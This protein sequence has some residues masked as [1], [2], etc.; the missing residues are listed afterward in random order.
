MNI[1]GKKI[2]SQQNFAARFAEIPAKIPEEDIPPLFLSESQKKMLASVCPVKYKSVSDMADTDY[3]E[4]FDFEY[5]PLSKQE[6]LPPFSNTGGRNIFVVKTITSLIPS[7]QI[8]SCIIDFLS[9]SFSVNDFYS[10]EIVDIEVKVKRFLHE[11]AVF[12]P[13]LEFCFLD[14]GLFG[15]QK[16]ASLKRLEQ[17][18][19]L[20]GFGGNSGTIFFSLSGQG[21]VGVDMYALK[22]YVETLPDCHIT[23][24]DMAHDDLEGLNTVV[25]FRDRFLAGDF[26]HV[27]RIAPKGRFYD[28]LGCDTGKTLYV[29]AKKHGKECC[30]YE[31][32]KQLGDKTS[33]WVRIE[34]RLTNVD[35]IIPFDV[36]INPAQYLAGLYPPFANL[37]AIH[38]HIATIKKIHGVAFTK[39]VESASIGYGK[40]FYYMRVNLGMK[41]AQ[42]CAAIE[43]KGIPKRLIIAETALM[44]LIPF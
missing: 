28:D 25:H 38:A 39:L 3:Q 1:I 33:K 24:I 17:N 15:Y 22:S 5:K 23:R 16:S 2:N 41:P 44:N 4:L 9:F 27:G 13:G 26:A 20:V 7:T 31:K 32:G 14:R 21:C 12:I 34:G 37:S 43:R 30:I 42:I 40:L 11:I 10:N 29:G 18:V 6:L 8:F 19:G 35:R 36:M